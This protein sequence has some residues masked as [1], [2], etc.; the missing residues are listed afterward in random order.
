MLLF[1]KIPDFIVNVFP[2]IEKLSGSAH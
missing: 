1:R 2:I